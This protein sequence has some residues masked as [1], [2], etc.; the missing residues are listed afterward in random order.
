[1][2][3]ARTKFK[4]GQKVVPTKRAVEAG[5]KWRA[6]KPVVGIVRAIGTHWPH[7]D[8]SVQVVGQKRV[9]SYHMDF[10]QPR[11]EQP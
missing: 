4:V 6:P 3:N 2:K 7:W 9:G 11:S 8:V 10:W 1:M 5:L